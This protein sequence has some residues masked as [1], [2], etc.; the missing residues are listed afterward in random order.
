MDKY[1]KEEL[2]RKR[3]T[4]YLIIFFIIVITMCLGLIV[5]IYVT[6]YFIYDKV[7]N[8]AIHVTDE[9]AEKSTPI[10]LNNVVIGAVYKNEWVSSARYY[11]MSK[12]KEQTELELFTLKGKAGT[13]NLELV[14]QV[15]S[16]VVGLTNSTNRIS[17]YV[18]TFK[19]ENYNY[20]PMVKLDNYKIK[21]EEY[22]SKIK[23]ALGLYNILNNSIKITNV[24]ENW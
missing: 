1:S 9:K 12:I 24:Y 23:D 16:N 15:N 21:E 4:K 17:E 5:Y 13:F 10:I 20:L 18:A 14:K 22:Q 19:N 6:N 7:N 3:W 8:D 2:V 11:N